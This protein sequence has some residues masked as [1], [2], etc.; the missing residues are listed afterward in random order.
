VLVLV[1]ESGI[2]SQIE[3]EYE[4]E[5]EYDPDLGDDVKRQLG[6][7]AAAAIVIANMIGVGVFTS[8][9]FQ[10]LGLHDSGTILMTWVVGGVVALCGAAAYAE[11]GAM[12]PRVGGEYVYLR[13]AYHPL[14]AVM[15][16]WGSLLAGFSAPIAAAA[17]AFA[18]YLGTVIGVVDPV[19]QK[20]I[21]IGLIIAATGMHATDAVIGGRVQ[22]VFTALKVGVIVV[23]V[24]LGLTIGTGDWDHFAP[25]RGGLAN[26]WTDEFAIA[27]MFVSL[28]YSGWNAATY[29]AGEIADP[30][31]NLPR[32]LLAG[33][34][35]V[36]VLYILLNVVFLYAVSP[37]V[38]ATP[39]Y[40]PGGPPAVVE[41]GDAAGRAL[42]GDV[43]GQLMSTLIALALVSA[44]S[45]MIMAGPRVYAAMAEDGA[46]P[47]VLGRRNKRGAP[48]FSVV[49][50][51]AIAI[52]FVVIGQLGELIRYVTFC[53]TIFAA[54]TVAAVFVLRVR[55]PDA[56][57]PYRTFGY[58]LTP[59]IFIAVSIWIAYAQIRANP[60]ESLGVLATLVSGALVYFK[61]L[62][63]GPQPPLPAEL[64]R[65]EIKRGDD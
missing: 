61:L 22:T 4:Y 17:L 29:I 35:I 52:A 63:R 50:Q 33:T 55:E 56:A 12:M 54:L 9:G 47:P 25:R 21:A 62:P 14:L 15:S 40:G 24:V 32:A 49:L 36:T 43:A 7:W 10:A 44:V 23:F 57:R 60:L 13:R 42:F 65:A 45:A 3:Y 53:I 64:P 39:P 41:V 26:V 27:L 5:Y 51:G 6:I 31:K 19:H 46:L 34:G 18:A 30:R 28:A 2:E 16:G 59:T 38:L 1:L 48:M 20:L 37:E 11:L 8:T 58:P